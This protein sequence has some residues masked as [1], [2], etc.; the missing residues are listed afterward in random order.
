[1]NIECLKGFGLRQL[2]SHAM[3]QIDSIYT[4]CS[5]KPPMSYWLG[6]SLMCHISGCLV[7][8]ATSTRR[9][10]TLASSKEDVILDSWLDIPQAS[11]HIGSTMSQPELLKK[12]M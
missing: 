5:R 6:G 4:V 11:R 2:T 1:M 7:A 9:D 12:L 8:S 3:L 10:N